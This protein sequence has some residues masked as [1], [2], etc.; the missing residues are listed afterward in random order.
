[1][2]RYVLDPNDVWHDDHTSVLVGGGVHI[3]C[4]DLV[5]TR[6]GQVYRDGAYRV[7]A[8]GKRTKVFKGE[9]AWSDADRLASDYAF[10]MRNAQDWWS[11]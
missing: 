10:E 6:S 3:Q 8:P 2:S 9:R 5:D 11:V 4:R 1:V 7:I